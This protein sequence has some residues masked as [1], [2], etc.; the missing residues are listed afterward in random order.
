MAGRRLPLPS[1]A[2]RRRRRIAAA[3]LLVLGV[4]AAACAVSAVNVADGSRE[5]RSALRAAQRDLSL[6]D[7]LDGTVVAQL[8]SA[9]DSFDD[10]NEAATSVVWLPLRPAPIIGRHLASARALTSSVRD[11]ARRIADTGEQ[12]RALVES[13]QPGPGGRLAVLHRLSSL[14]VE[15]DQVVDDVDLGPDDALVGTLAD[16]RHDVAVQVDD[17]ADGVAQAT[18]ALATL[19]DLLEG[20]RSTLV[21]AAN[22]AEMRA[23]AGMLLSV[24][25]LH[26]EDGRSEVS[27]FVPVEDVA[28]PPG[29]VEI[30]AELDSL[31][32]WAQP[33]VELRNLLLSPRFP[34]AASVAADAWAATGRPPVD[35]VLAVDPVALGAIVDVTG[36]VQVGAESFDGTTIV[37]ELLHEQYVRFDREDRP[38]RQERSADVAE[39][40]L[41]EV[42]DGSWDLV[43]MAEALQR[44]VAGRHLL[45]WSRAAP[46]QTGWEALGVEGDLD[47]DSVLVALNSRGAG[48]TDPFMRM[49]ATMTTESRDSGIDVRVSICVANRVPEGEPDTVTTDRPDISLAEGEYRGILVASV[50]AGARLVGFEGRDM[51]NVAGPDGD[52]EVVGYQIELAR[53]ATEDAVLHFRL[54]PSW[55]SLVVEPSA[56]V[57]AVRWRDA[58]GAWRDRQPERRAL[59]DGAV[60]APSCER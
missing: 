35:G 28:A 7:L 14:I 40:V 9:A 31:W 20:P 11:L 55:S 21:F 58:A 10:A 41:R 34:V 1:C 56:R 33:D 12:A 13:A 5:G 47:A 4:W 24:G 27:D 2:M 57:P 45:A 8:E 43:D 51:L 16:A 53:G 50:P 17:L 30:P 36:P 19:T 54:P 37:D 6:R 52:S 23:G 25:E 29:S 39:A 15:L 42:V 3:I 26:T 48:K 22:N 38:E 46:A 32:G 18:T 44:T 49:E 60:P 59:A